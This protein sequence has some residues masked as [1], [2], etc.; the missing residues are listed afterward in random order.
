[1][2]LRSKRAPPSPPNRIPVGGI[3]VSSG[4]NLRL[5][6]TATRNWPM[7]RRI[8]IE[9]GVAARAGLIVIHLVEADAKFVERGRAE[10]MQVLERDIVVLDAL[11][12]RE[13]GID[14]VDHIVAAHCGEAPEDLVL[15]AE[16]VIYA[17]EI[18]I[19]IEDIRHRADDV[20]V[21]NV[22]R[23]RIEAAAGNC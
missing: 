6:S 17:R 9:I 1:M 19:L 12:A 20:D 3:P 2:P 18:L 11:R 7:P 8:E 16:L 13:I 15:R 21:E 4:R 5:L 14:V 22:R 10:Q 23:A